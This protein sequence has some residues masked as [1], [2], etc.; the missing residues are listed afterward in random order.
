MNQESQNSLFTI[1][2]VAKLTGLTAHTLRAW[3]NRYQAIV[4]ARSSAGQRTYTL[5]DVER[6]RFLKKLTDF[7]Y[8]ISKVANEPLEKLR[9]LSSQA[10]NHEDT[11]QESINS[12]QLSP[13]NA[14]QK[15]ANYLSQ[16]NT[17]E[18]MDILTD[19]QNYDLASI[20][21]KMMDS[22]V[23]LG[24][25]N[26]AL[27]IVLPL[28]REVGFLYAS[29]KISIAQEHALSAVVRNHL[30]Q[31][32]QVIGWNIP[33]DHPKIALSTPAND[34]HEIPIMIAQVVCLVSGFQVQ[35]LGPNLPAEALAD[36][37]RAL[38]C[39]IILLGATK[40]PPESFGADLPAYLQQLDPLLT[41]NQLLW[42]GGSAIVDV[43]SNIC[44][45]SSLSLLSDMHELENKLTAFR[46]E[47]Y[48]NLDS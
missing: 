48:P 1:K 47:R 21:H 44:R 9:L 34:I 26:F 14:S 4:P 37:A 29:G 7:G 3:E 33:Q 32:I 42:V 10:E 30:G 6:L 2:T 25:K 27:E 39:E 36:T 16:T 24:A 18:E 35:F 11:L 22:R 19:L 41:P 13:R 5:G 38:Q 12:M 8:P 17:L 28:M 43:E 31:I 46:K 23:A 15:K 40:T 45:N 20:N